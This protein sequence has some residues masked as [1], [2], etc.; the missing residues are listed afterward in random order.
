MQLGVRAGYARPY[1]CFCCSFYS[2]PHPV[3]MIN[4][5]FLIGIGL[6]LSLGGFVAPSVAAEPPI[7]PALKAQVLRIIRENPGVILEAIADYQKSQTSQQRLG[8]AALLQQIKTKPSLAI[9]SSA[10]K[11]QPIGQTAGAPKSRLVIFTFSDFQCPY[12]AK[13]RI[14]MDQFLAKHP[15]ATLVFKHFPLTSI[16]PQA[17]PASMAAWAAA[18]QNKFWEFHDALFL[19]QTQLGDRLYLDTATALKLDLAKFNRDRTSDP[20]R[21][22]IQQDMQLA[23]QL[24]IEGTPFFVMNGEAFHGATQAA[25]FEAA[26]KAQSQ[27][28][29]KAQT[30]P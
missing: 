10:T 8:Q 11:G 21:K 6:I 22:A 13:S 29:T 1:V 9:G 30:N 3:P 27:T 15:E 25:D 28:P 14:G 4:S 5:R 20:A 26:L 12:C 7:D 16:H 2:V 18:Q 19:N 17:L 24:G 23:Q